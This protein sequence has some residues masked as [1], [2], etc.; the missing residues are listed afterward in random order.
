MDTIRSDTTKA[1]RTKSKAD[2]AIERQTV[3][4]ERHTQTAVI[5]KQ[6]AV[7]KGIRFDQ[8]DFSALIEKG[9]PCVLKGAL[10]DAPLVKAGL[11]SDQDA[12]SYLRSSASTAPFLHYSADAKAQR[13]FFYNDKIDGL[14]FTVQHSP[15]GEFF[16]KIDTEKNK[17]TGA[18]FYIGSAALDDHFPGLL[19]QDGLQLKTGIFETYPPRTGIWIGNQTIASSHFDVSN[20]IAAC[21]VGK[22]RFTL[23]PPDQIKNLY[24]GPLEPTPGGQVVSMFNTSHPDYDQYPKAKDALAC[25][26]VAELDP[27]D[28]LVYPAMWWHQVEAIADFNVMI[29]Y[30]WNTVPEFVDDPMT[31][32]LHGMLSLRDRPDHEKQAWRALF[33]FYVFGDADQ[34]RDYLP[35]HAW[36]HLAPMDTINSRRLRAK[37]LKR[38]N[39]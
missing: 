5:E 24:P 27:G 18:S 14:N 1:K 16:D 32:L 21:M 28:V 23:F 7:I 2:A 39:R 35:H 3:A 22:R 29:N 11:A 13:R 33:D 17:K 20:N 12:M 10:N 19:E 9:T 15:L 37:L 26:Q 31:T 6:T 4:I 8:A 36:G 38:F 30:W 34:A 25:A